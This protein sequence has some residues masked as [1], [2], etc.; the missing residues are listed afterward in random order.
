MIR[1]GI[2]FRRIPFKVEYEAGVYKAMPLRRFR[3]VWQQS[4]I[5]VVIRQ[6]TGHKL[7]VRLP[8]ADDKRVWLKASHRTKP[9]WV[10]DGKYWELPQ[11][12]F[13]DFVQRGLRR[14]GRLYVIQP[15]VEKEVCAPACWNANGHECQC[16][17][18]G[19]NHGSHGGGGWFVVSDTF[20]V[21]VSSSDM[22][23]RLMTLSPS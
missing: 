13:N 12:W 16:S 22:A 7:N 11:A 20:A 2:V 3:E 8:F 15:Y 1:K 19:A 9:I 18:M 14:Y 17:C 21:R 6:G 23:C 10:N 5:P 4:R